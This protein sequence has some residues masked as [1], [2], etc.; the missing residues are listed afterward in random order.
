[1]DV[2][3]RGVATDAVTGLDGC[4]QAPACNWE[5]PGE[6]RP[7]VSVV[8]V[9]DDDHGEFEPRHVPQRSRAEDE[10]AVADETN[11]LL[12]RTREFHSRR[13]ANAGAEMSAVIEEQLAPPDRIEV[14]R[15]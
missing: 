11:H 15:V 13:R 1:G 4:R 3:K 14:E 9:D 10:G 6:R 7:A 8:V 2:D 5:N 12:V